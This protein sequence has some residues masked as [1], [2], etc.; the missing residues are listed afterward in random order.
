[1][2]LNLRSRLSFLIEIL[3]GKSELFNHAALLSKV[4]L[5][6]LSL[7]RIPFS[8]YSPIIKLR[9]GDVVFECMTSYEIALYQEIF[10]DR[11]YSSHN[12]FSPAAIGNDYV[13]IDIGANI[14]L[15][16]VYLS[17]NNPAGRIYAFEP[18]GSI[19]ARLKRNLSLNKVKNV[20]IIEAA[21]WSK[22][23]ELAFSAEKYSV[24][25]RVAEGNVPGEGKVPGMTLDAS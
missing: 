17:M 22:N 25:S 7:I 9:A 4:K 14:G 21:L 19:I 13:A 18:N 1:M 11:T 23:S 2:K 24:L 15:Y 20:E 12:S 10:L 8:T 5:F 6:C 16:S 3:T